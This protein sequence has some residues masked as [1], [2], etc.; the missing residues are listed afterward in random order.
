[1]LVSNVHFKLFK[2]IISVHMH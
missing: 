1:M 2:N